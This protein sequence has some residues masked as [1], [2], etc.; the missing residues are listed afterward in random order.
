MTPGVLRRS[1]SCDSPSNCR[2][3]IEGAERLA[4]AAGVCSV[5]ERAVIRARDRTKVG[6][7]GSVAPALELRSIKQKKGFVQ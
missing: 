1:T 5:E 7:G 2:S 6:F 3:G 4:T